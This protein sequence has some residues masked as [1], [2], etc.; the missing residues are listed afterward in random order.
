[1]VIIYK[2]GI[3]A[4]KGLSSLKKKKNNFKLENFREFLE[5]PNEYA[6]F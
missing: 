3:K 5:F 6:E 2:G 4:E 1:L